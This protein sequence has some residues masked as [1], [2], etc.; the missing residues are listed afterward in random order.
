MEVKAKDENAPPYKVR[1][2][3][4]FH[5]FTREITPEDG[6]DLHME[7]GKEKRCFCHE[8]YNL[9]KELA[10][11]IRYAAAG[12]AYFG[13]RG[14]FLIVELPGEGNAPYVA[15]FDVEK[16]KKADGF[17]GAMFV[18]SA[19]LRL[20]LPEKLPAVSFI[21]VVDYRI[22]GKKLTRPTPRNVIAQ[23]RK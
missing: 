12:R 14:N 20:K 9:S 18:T 17:D 22:S 15:F 19:H 2:S 4:G 11:M 23:K 13:D 8:R 1:V 5:C 7:H 21:T 3:F 16:A 6:P 10:D